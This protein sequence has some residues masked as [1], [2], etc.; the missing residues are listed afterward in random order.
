VANVCSVLLANTSPI[1]GV[2]VAKIVQRIH[3]QVQGV[4][5]QMLAHVTPDSLAPTEAPVYHVGLART[6]QNLERR[7][8][9]YVAQGK[10][11]QSQLP[12]RMCARVTLEQ[13]DPTD[14]RRVRR[15]ISANTR[16]QQGLLCVQSVPPESRLSYRDQQKTSAL[17]TQ[18]QQDRMVKARACRVMLANTRR[19]QDLLYVWRA[20]QESFLQSLGR[21]PMCAPATLE[22]LGPMERERVNHVL[23]APT[24]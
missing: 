6:R 1:L 5:P 3:S 17:V 18:G 12:L 16:Q 23:L 20:Q 9:H 7:P 2:P 24:R 22:Q 4:P 8:A 19:P 21:P 11:P 15:V 10:I 13:L 14:L